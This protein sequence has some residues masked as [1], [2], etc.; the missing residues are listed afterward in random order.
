MNR[1]E[2][3]DKRMRKGVERER[4]TKSVQ[5]WQRMDT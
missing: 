2:T 5:E 4:E 1:Q 3:V